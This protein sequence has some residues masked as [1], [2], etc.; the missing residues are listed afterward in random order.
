[1][2][3]TDHRADNELHWFNIINSF[4]IVLFLASLASIILSRMLN[5]DIERYN[6]NN[7]LDDEELGVLNQEHEKR[8][9]GWKQIYGDIFRPPLDNPMLYAACMGAGSHMVLVFSIVLFFSMM[10]IMNPSHRGSLI[11]GFFV[12]FILGKT[13]LYP[14][15]LIK[16]LFTNLLRL[17]PVRLAPVHLSPIHFSPI[18][19]SPIRL[20]PIHLSPIHLSPIRLSTVK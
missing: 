2:Y 17:T 4:L 18:H 1:M 14:I 12:V 10:G 19:F 16:Q 9:A 8:N 3:L 13:L 15:Y 20:S 5:T 11:I 6:L 7:E